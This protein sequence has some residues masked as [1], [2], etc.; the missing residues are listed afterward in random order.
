MSTEYYD[1]RHPWGEVEVEETPE[2]FRITL[3]DDHGSE[4]GSLTL[5][6]EVGQEAVLHFFRDEP[7]CQSYY[8]GQG[9]VLYELRE[10]RT[11]TLVDEYGSLVKMEELRKSCLRSHESEGAGDGA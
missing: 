11:A 4:A 9:R 6:P 7:V 5:R 2:Y 3:W 10:A 8:N 1:P